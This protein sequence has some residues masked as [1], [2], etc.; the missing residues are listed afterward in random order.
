MTIVLRPP[1]RNDYDAIAS[2]IPDAKACLRWASG[3]CGW[4]TATPC[5]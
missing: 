5:A 1:E 3:S 4:A 2:W